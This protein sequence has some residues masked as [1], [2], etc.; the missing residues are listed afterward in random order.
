LHFR[1]GPSCSWI[2]TAPL[3][4]SFCLGLF[5]LLG[6][7]L[8]VEWRWI[9]PPPYSGFTIA[10]LVCSGFGELLYLIAGLRLLYRWGKAFRIDTVTFDRLRQ[11]VTIR[12]GVFVPLSVSE[13]YFAEV[14][15]LHIGRKTV[16]A[17]RNKDHLVYPVSLALA[18]DKHAPLLEYDDYFQARRMAEEAAAY[19]SL[20]LIDATVEPPQFIEADKVGKPLR[21]AQQG[22]RARPTLAPLPRGSRCRVAWEEETAVVRL[23]I[24]GL[25]FV[26]ADSLKGAVILALISAGVGGCVWWM[27][28]DSN[29]TAGAVLA[30]LLIFW[31]PWL[32]LFLLKWLFF[33]LRATT[34]RVDGT[35][36]H[37]R[38]RGL[39]YRSTRRISH[40][41]LR[42]IR[43]NE[44]T[45]EILTTREGL[46][47]GD[48]LTAAE[49]EWLSDALNKLAAG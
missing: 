6:A 13:V 29:R 1:R 49:R 11:L 4:L 14:E 2:I 46:R 42:S 41:E 21:T 33:K 8:V 28:K 48:K 26:L 32:S 37:Y 17:K 18:D 30:T 47:F 38:A 5:A 25:P 16:H 10:A 39:L 34:I 22:V 3:Y 27:T 7:L 36:L 40:A 12:K 44:N 15:A 31:L 24:A 35:G 9:G 20:S 43:V 19:A 23:P 45:V